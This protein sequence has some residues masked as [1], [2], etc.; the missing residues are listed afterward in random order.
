[1][2]NYS[3]NFV[4]SKLANT[5][6][7]EIGEILNKNLE[8]KRINSMKKVSMKIDL[9]WKNI[10]KWNNAMIHLNNCYKS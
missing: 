5:Q 7:I 9:S 8:I 2:L 1:M 4:N 3:D 10:N 6:I